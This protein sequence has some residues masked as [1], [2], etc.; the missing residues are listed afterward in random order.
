MKILVTGGTGY[1]GGFMT[2]RLLEEE[3]EVVVID[4]LEKSSKSHIDQ[5]VQFIQGNLQDQL[6]LDKV[7]SKHQFDSII[8]F[9]GYISMGESMVKPGMYFSNNVGSSIALLEKAVLHKVKSFIFSSTAGV[10]GNP[11][12]IPIPENHPTKPTNPY[13]ESKH[14]VEQILQWYDRIHG[15]RFVSLRYFNAAGASF[16]GNRGEQH[17]P[18]T[19]LIPNAIKAALSHD[20]FTLFGDDYATNDGTCVRDYIHVID[21]VEAHILSLKKLQNG[22]ESA[23]YNIGTGEGHTNKKVI[24]AVKKISGIDFPVLIGKRRTGDA[25]TLIADPAKIKSELGFTPKYSNLELIIETAWKWHSGN[26]RQ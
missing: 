21:L 26:Y 23:I 17:Q 25:E 22:G 13:G 8:H 9:A 14:I 19:H 15:L 6:F 10:Y 11:I 18:E 1:I 2:S 20:Q 5:K 16:N 4:S 12:K 3:Y 24:L 7:F